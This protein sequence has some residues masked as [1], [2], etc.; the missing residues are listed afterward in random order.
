MKNVPVLINNFNRLEPL[1]QQL[2]WLSTLPGVSEIIISDNASNYPP[3]LDYYEKN[4][5]KVKIIRNTHNGGHNMPKNTLRELNISDR[6]I[7]TDPDL[8]P[9]PDT[10]S[11]IIQKLNTL[12]DTHPNYHKVGCGLNINDLPDHYPFTERIRRHETCLLG[13]TFPDGSREACIDTTFCLYRCKEA[14]GGWNAPAIRTVK[15]YILKHI[16]WYVNPKDITEE[17]AWYLD[18]CT[19]SAS[20]ATQ[21]KE[22]LKLHKIDYHQ[23]ALK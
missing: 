16:D 21:L 6:V 2:E 11:D 14:F 20:Y 12:M 5:Y 9:Y 17:Y 22:W 13:K 18:N 1:K 10:P 4:P 3:L 8:I 19:S 23:K 7:V 15:P